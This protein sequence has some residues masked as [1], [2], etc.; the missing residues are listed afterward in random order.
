MYNWRT[1]PRPDQRTKITSRSRRVV[2]LWVTRNLGGRS[3]K[4]KVPLAVAF[5][6]MTC[7]AKMQG[8]SQG[9]SKKHKFMC[10]S[11]KATGIIFWDVRSVM[12]GIYQMLH[13][14]IRTF[15]HLCKVV[16]IVSWFAS[17]LLPLDSTESTLTELWTDHTAG[18][19]FYKLFHH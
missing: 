7:M 9:F 2:V 12:F 13:C 1:L 19:W 3:R 4:L 17:A 18:Q 14:S 16:V 8:G 15:H 5:R 10:I 6:H 11:Q